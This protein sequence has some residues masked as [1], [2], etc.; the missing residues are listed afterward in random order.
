M[1]DLDAKGVT[2]IAR[3]RT[4]ERGDIDVTEVRAFRVD[5]SD[6]AIDDPRE[7][8]ARTRWPEKEPVEDWSMGIP[9]AARSLTG[10]GSWITLLDGRVSA[11]TSYLSHARLEQLEP[12]FGP[13]Q[14]HRPIERITT[15]QTRTSYFASTTR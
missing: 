15:C 1:G 12:S 10:L 14:S 3:P 11:A 6:A 4:E 9:R 13:A 2:V 5:I 8:L 7:R